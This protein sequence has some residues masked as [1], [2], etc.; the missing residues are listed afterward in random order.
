MRGMRNQSETTEGG[1]KNL[2]L[3]KECDLLVKNRTETEQ[4]FALNEK[5]R[6]NIMLVEFLNMREFLSFAQRVF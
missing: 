4:A 3:K 5:H 6:G 2:D 1:L